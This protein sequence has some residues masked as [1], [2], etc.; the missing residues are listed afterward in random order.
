MNE[1]QLKGKSLDKLDVRLL[2]IVIILAVFEFE[3][4][5]FA[6]GLVELAGQDVWLSV[7]LGTFALLMV[8]YLLVKLTGRFPREDLFQYSKRVWGK[9]LAFIISVSYLLY[10]FVFLAVLFNDFSLANR[11]LFLPETPLLIPM[12]L[13]GIGALWLAAYGFTALVKFFQ[14]MFPFMAVLLFI[15]VGLS[16]KEISFDNFLPVF[17]NGYVPIF[18]GALFYLGLFQGVEVILFLAPF[19]FKPQNAV[20]P[21]FLGIGVLSIFA[22]TSAG[23]AVGTLGVENVKTTVWPGLATVSIIHLPGFPVERFELF[24]TLPWLIAIFTTIWVSGCLLK[25]STI[26]KKLCRASSSPTRTSLK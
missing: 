18:K 10:W 21:A 3:L 12:M 9:P 11:L 20:K 15:V 4:F 23:A 14:L 2:T 5:S 19:L 6:R 8:I 22:F 24:L 1:Q 16:L 26:S 13:I 25:K 17:S 7:L